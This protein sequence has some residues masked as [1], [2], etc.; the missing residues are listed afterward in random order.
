MVVAHIRIDAHNVGP[1]PFAINEREFD[2]LS[3][4]GEHSAGFQRD[5]SARGCLTECA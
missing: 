1:H 5:L 4:I 3:V 2:N